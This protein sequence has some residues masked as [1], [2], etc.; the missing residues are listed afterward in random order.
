MILKYHLKESEPKHIEPRAHR[1][2]IAVV[3]KK[4]RRMTMTMKVVNRALVQ[5]HS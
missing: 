5:R 1:E 2:V 3:M 4:A